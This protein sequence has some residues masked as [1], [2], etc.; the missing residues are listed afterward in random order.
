MAT[1]ITAFEGANTVP[2]LL[3]RRYGKVAQTI[4]LKFD[5][6]KWLDAAPSFDFK[7]R[8]F[9]FPV[10]TGPGGGF[11]AYAEGGKYP[12]SVKP[13]I[14]DAT[15]PITQIA[16][17]VAFSNLDMMLGKSDADGFLRNTDK[18]V[19][20]A[21]ENF[22]RKMNIE[23][24]GL[25]QY[26]KANGVA[27]IADIGKNGLINHI[28]SVAGAAPT[29]TLGVDQPLGYANA[30]LGASKYT[31]YLIPGDVLAYGSVV[32]NTYT[33]KGH[34][35]VNSVNRSANTVSVTILSSAGG[36][37]A[38][39]VS[40]LGDW[41]CYADY[42]LAT[43][44][45]YG[46]MPQGLGTI[47]YQDQLDGIDQVIEGVTVTS[48]DPLGWFSQKIT[49]AG[50]FDQTDWHQ[51]NRNIEIVSQGPETAIVND[52]TMKDTYAGTIVPDQR[53]VA[54][55][56]KGGFKEPEFASGRPIK[57]IY[58]MH[59]PYGVSFFLSK[60]EIFWLK[61]M[62]EPGW[63]N[64]GGGQWKSFQ[65]QDSVYAAFKWYYNVGFQNLNTHGAV[66]G[67]QIANAPL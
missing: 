9:V 20:L 63:D 34:L 22:K 46:R 25:H 66:K 55:E 1:P 32:G 26:K 67:I 43:N 24:Y 6:Y 50:P 30:D 3:K 2:N 59:C 57:M 62:A 45:S 39:G 56:A 64:A 19:Q 38:A 5:L 14:T 40:P 53:L 15:L 18:I 60:E 12:G 33:T 10:I 65:Q 36:L 7:G 47:L 8:D 31:R 21:V 11:T 41:L 48:N 28:T 49:S 58:D 35:Q 54:Q 4:P 17:L 27:P 44:N 61:T 52:P 13:V 37:P 42:D 51:L 16:T 23:L 29:M